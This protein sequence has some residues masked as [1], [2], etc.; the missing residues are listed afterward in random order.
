MT[1]FAGRGYYRGDLYAMVKD[2]LDAFDRLPPEE[3]EAMR[4]AQ[5]V[6]WLRGEL[7][8]GLDEREEK[9]R[10]IYQRQAARSQGYT[11][12]QCSHCN[13]MRMKVAGHCMVCEDCGTT[14]GCS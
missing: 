1:N 11:G 9:D 3:Q 5:Q 14:T 2:S 4:K 12:D 13:S 10:A 6:S 8:I 7:A